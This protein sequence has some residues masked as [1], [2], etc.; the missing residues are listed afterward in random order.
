MRSA[1]GPGSA[2]RESELAR[3]MATTTAALTASRRVALLFC[4]L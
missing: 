4:P 1:T 2:A 3:A